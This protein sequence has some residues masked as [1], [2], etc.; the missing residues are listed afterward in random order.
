MARLPL[1]ADHDNLVKCGDS[2]REEK[3]NVGKWDIEDDFHSARKKFNSVY[4]EFQAAVKAVLRHKTAIDETIARSK[5][6]KEEVARVWR[7]NRDKLRLFIESKGLHPVIAK[8]VADLLYSKVSP[9]EKSNVRLQI[10]SPMV[11]LSEIAEV[12]KNTF[13]Q[14]IHIVY[15]AAALPDSQHHLEQELA[16]LFRENQ[17]TA[18]TK[19]RE[20][21]T[22][23]IGPPAVGQAIGALDLATE[24]KWNPADLASDDQWFNPIKVRHALWTTWTEQGDLTVPSWPFQRLAGFLVNFVGQFVVTVVDSATALEH[25]GDIQQYVIGMETNDLHKFPSYVLKEGDALWLPLG[26]IPII[27]SQQMKVQAI[28]SKVDLKERTT[29]GVQRHPSALGVQ[30][31]LDIT[32]DGAASPDLRRSVLASWVRAGDY[33]PPSWKQNAEIAQWKAS[34]EK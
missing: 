2:L 23:M 34:L 27:S 16:T 17:Q 25:G 28:T 29:V 21:V 19:M 12:N 18:I 14:P 31:C 5:K 11:N 20:C 10:Y 33:L 15:N 8:L 30:V 26:T 32:A 3:T 24:F 22:C 1:Q 13:S 4:S 9:P 7:Q 6:G